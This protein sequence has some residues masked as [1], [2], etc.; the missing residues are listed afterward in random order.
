MAPALPDRHF[1]AVQ[2]FAGLHGEME[3]RLKCH[4]YCVGKFR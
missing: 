3:L 1:V 4:D 2:W